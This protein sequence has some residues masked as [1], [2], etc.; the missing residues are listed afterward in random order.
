M[1][2]VA[3]TGMGAM[4]P[5][6]RGVDRLWKQVASGRTCARRIQTFDTSA[7]RCQIGGEVVEFDPSEWLHVRL[8]RRTARF[9]HL[10]MA[11]ATM[12]IRDAGLEIGSGTGVAPDRA[13]ISVGNVL[14]GWDFAEQEL[15]KLWMR[16]PRHVSPFL[17]TAWFPTAPQGN[18]SIAFGIKGRART[19]VSDRASG[20]YAIIHA[21]EMIQ[22]GQADVVIAG[23][24]EQPMSATAVLCCQTSGYLTRYGGGEPDA[25]YRPFDRRHGGA[26]VG[27]GSVFLVLEAMDHALGR[28]A[29]LLA[30]ISGWAATADGYTP[31]YTVDPR[32]TGLI[33]A[34]R[35]ATGRA[36]V[37]PRD[38]DFV[39]ADGSAVPSEDA[40]EVLAIKATMGKGTSIPVTAAK[41]ALTHLLGAAAVADVAVAVSAMAAGVIPPIAHFEEPAPG[42]DLDFVHG[43]CREARDVSRVLVVSRGLGGVNACLVVGSCPDAGAHAAAGGTA[44]N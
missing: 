39:V 8:V 27:E 44:S 22:R 38:L 7:L 15:T 26:V 13:A 28:G 42:F 1:R 33:A 24:T 36:G 2:R 12:A 16:G 41:P 20:A 30:E 5:A 43:S 18:I 25:A 32:A 40:T 17:A 31:L 4:T 29:R 34:I 6:G 10:A 23:G 14:G 9:T 3:V 37:S 21:A 11:A 35:Q 19:F